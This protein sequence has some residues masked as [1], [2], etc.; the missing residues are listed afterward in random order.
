MHTG[1]LLTVH[2]VQC[3]KAAAP[4][5]VIFWAA[6]R[7]SIIIITPTESIICPLQSCSCTVKT[8]SCWVGLRGLL[9]S[10]L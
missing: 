8:S 6:H 9:A 2:E 1:V 10:S 3:I 5:I 4:I 7:A